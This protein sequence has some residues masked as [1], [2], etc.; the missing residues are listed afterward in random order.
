V[1]WQGIAR[2]NPLPPALRRRRRAAGS[3]AA[4][5]GSQ[6]R[7]RC[8]RLGGHLR[9]VLAHLVPRDRLHAGGQERRQVQREL[10]VGAVGRGM[11]LPGAG[12]DWTPC[13]ERSHQRY[14]SEEELLT[15]PPQCWWHR[16]LLHDLHTSR[17]NSASTMTHPSMACMPL[18][19]CAMQLAWLACLTCRPQRSSSCVALT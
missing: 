19:V 13:R 16:P 8:P 2:P 15:C 14:S 12:L 3:L 4:E 7:W 10:Q 6:D 18:T 17:W 1:P 5:A 9:R 11:D